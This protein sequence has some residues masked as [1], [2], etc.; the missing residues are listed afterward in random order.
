MFPRTAT[1]VATLC[2]VQLAIAT[3]TVPPFGHDLRPYFYFDDNF[4]QYNHGEFEG[5]VLNICMSCCHPV[6]SQSD[7]IHS[8]RCRAGAYGGTP[9]PVLEAQF[10]YMQIMERD[11]DPF[12]NGDNGYRACIASARAT[13]G[14]LINANTSNLDDLVLV[15]NASEAINAI[16]RNMEPPLS[17]DEYI[18]DLSTAYG[19]FVGLYTWLGSREGVKTITVPIQWPVTGPESFID[20][21]RAT[22]EANA[23]TLNIRVAVISQIT[24]YPAVIVPV[25]A[26]CNLFHAHGI[27]VIVDGAHA[28]GNIA[29]DLQSMGDPDYAFWNI[30][31][32]YFGPK[33]AALMY[34]RRDH[35]LLHVPAP[36]VVDSPETQ[37]FIERFIWT[38][39]RDRTAY[40]AIQAATDFRAALGGEAAVQK[41][42]SDLALSA[43]H[44]LTELW[45]VAPMAPDS[46]Y[47]GSALVN[48][49]IPT[50]NSTAC[51]V[52]RSRLRDLGLGMSGWTAISGPPAITCYFRISG[53][54]RLFAQMP[55]SSVCYCTT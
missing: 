2:G 21:V 47:A 1:L 3:S 33:S 36:A 52:L 16:I 23:S 19:P 29:V 18:L 26:L 27:P 17:A 49:Q 45:G 25:R 28:L 38:G 48:V 32:W 14:A 43:A 6:F 35:Q 22:L 13:L 4:T 7:R 55:S 39:T 54:V 8:P 10:G 31:K 42:N 12:M 50:Q 11:I 44:Y 51:G 53:M 30:H 24:A 41:Y 37:P 34:V 20:P 9:R 40:C 5:P 46:M 15:D